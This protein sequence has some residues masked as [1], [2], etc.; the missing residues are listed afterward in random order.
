[1]CAVEPEQGVSGSAACSQV[2][3][4]GLVR[5][6]SK[7]K[8]AIPTRCSTQQLQDD[9]LISDENSSDMPAAKRRN[10]E[11]ATTTETASTSAGEQTDSQPGKSVER[12]NNKVHE[13]GSKKEEDRENGRSDEAVGGTVSG[14][15][16]GESDSVPPR[17]STPTANDLPSVDHE[18]GSPNACS[19]MSDDVSSIGSDE[20][21]KSEKA[22]NADKDAVDAGSHCALQSDNSHTD[23]DDI[24]DS[25]VVLDRVGTRDD[26][27]YRD[28]T[29]PDATENGVAATAKDGCVKASTQSGFVC[30]VEGCNA[31][32]PSKRSRD[33]HSANLNLHRKL[34]STSGTSAKSTSAIFTEHPFP[35]PIVVHGSSA[36]AADEAGCL[37]LNLSRSAENNSASTAGPETRAAAAAAAAVNDPVDTV[38]QAADTDG[39]ASRSSSV[40]PDEEPGIVG[41]ESMTVSCHVCQPSSV[42]FRDKLALKEHLE[43]VHPRETHRCT[44]AGC[45][46]LFSTRKSR[47]RH[48]QNDNLHRHLVVAA[49]RQ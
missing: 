30:L 6:T 19:G 41:S 15:G 44:V 45:D 2:S 16:D 9:E 31:T 1:M 35:P 27:L 24:N 32:F 17:T 5:G 23:H 11:P 10:V 34:L 33:R 21:R 47:N 18:P 28:K 48:S 4:G 12:N 14:T 46:K 40:G 7:R 42:T 43:T 22:I 8:S 37:V 25:G 26:E 38:S 20:D 49:P 39:E 13:Q 3:C 29:T 36:S